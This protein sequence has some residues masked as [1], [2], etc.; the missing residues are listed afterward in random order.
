MSANQKSDVHNQADVRSQ[1]NIEAQNAK[2]NTP[3]VSQAPGNPSRPSSEPVIQSGGRG[4][5]GGKYGV[6]ITTGHENAYGESQGRS[7]VSE[8]FQQQT[9]GNSQDYNAMASE[10]A[11]SLVVNR[12]LAPNSAEFNTAFQNYLQANRLEQTKPE[13]A[14]SRQESAKPL[15]YDENY[16]YSGSTK[17][18]PIIANNFVKNPLE[19]NFDLSKDKLAAQYRRQSRDSFNLTPIIATPQSEGKFFGYAWAS[20]QRDI[21]RA[22]IFTG[23]TQFSRG[24]TTE[25]TAKNAAIA[26]ASKVYPTFA[27]GNPLRDTTVGGPIKSSGG[28]N[29]QIL[30]TENLGIGENISGGQQPK[31]QKG[32][33]VSEQVFNDYLSNIGSKGG[34]ID[35]FA[36]SGAK[37]GTV[38]PDEFG[39][40]VINDIITSNPGSYVKESFTSNYDSGLARSFADYVSKYGSEGATIGLF[41]GKTKVAEVSG[42]NAYRETIPLL[43]KY[44]NLSAQV[45]FST[46]RE[47]KELS[48][49]LINKARTVGS[50]TIDIF[51]TPQVGPPSKI[52]TIPT[53]KAQTLLP[54]ILDKYA[55]QN[56]SFSFNPK[57][58]TNPKDT[59]L[60]PASVLPLELNYQSSKAFTGQYFNLEQ[61]IGG[62]V[63]GQKAS[64]QL[65]L[66]SSEYKSSSLFGITVPNF[67]GTIS[68]F[69]SN[70]GAYLKEGIKSAP[71]FVAGIGQEYYNLI[72]TGKSGG[73]EV[74]PA[75]L[76]AYISIPLQK[77]F[78]PKDIMA[79]N[80][81]QRMSNVQSY[82]HTTFG[83]PIRQSG[84]PI[85]QSVQNPKTVGAFLGTAAGIGYSFGS[86]LPFGKLISREPIILEGKVMAKMPS[87]EGFVEVPGTIKIS[88]AT[89]F[90]TSKYAIGLGM[91]S[92]EGTKIPLI[93]TLR[94]QTPYMREILGKVEA[95][96]ERGAEAG[97]V[98]N[99]T[100][101][102]LYTSKG[103]EVMSEVGVVPENQQQLVNLGQLISKKGDITK[104]PNVKIPKSDV[105]KYVGQMILTGNPEVNLSTTETLGQGQV[106]GIVPT[107]KG[108]FGNVLP[109]N[110]FNKELSLESAKQ[111]ST[112]FTSSSKTFPINFPKSETPIPVRDITTIHDL[113]AD[114]KRLEKQQNL[115]A[116]KGESIYKNTEEFG[117][118]LKQDVEQ[119]NKILD[120]LQANVKV[121]KGFGFAK[122]GKTNIAYGKISSL[123]KQG[124]PQNVEGET[125]INLLGIRDEINTE[126]AAGKS[127]K[128]TLGRSFNVE[129]PKGEVNYGGLKVKTISFQTWAKL[130]SVLSYQSK[131][132]Y[133]KYQNAEPDIYKT[134]LTT[135]AGK[136]NIVSPPL[137]RVKDV[138]DLYSISRY[139]ERTTK[140]G[141]SKRFGQLAN[142]LQEQYP[143]LDWQKIGLESKNTV[144]QISPQLKQ[145]A[146]NNIPST[147]ISPTSVFP[148][149]ISSQSQQSKKLVSSTKSSF[150][151]ISRISGSSYKIS[152]T[153]KSSPTS[154][155]SS[156]SALSPT[157]PQFSP[158]SKASPISSISKSAKSFL[159]PFI[160]PRSF[161]SPSVS[162]P[163]SPR[164]SYS[165]ST[166]SSTSPS[167]RP[168]PSSPSGRTSPNS[169]FSPISPTSP[170]SRANQFKS[171]NF[172]FPP[173]SRN[174]PIPR[175]GSFPKRPRYRPKEGPTRT[176]LYNVNNVFASSLSLKAG[177]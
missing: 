146:K 36:P 23:Q 138:P 144:Y 173:P 15:S 109:I 134:G 49:N 25:E 165:P 20:G 176:Y 143:Y 57:S 150:S 120:L 59:T 128:Y 130:K 174:I 71:P 2:A 66:T 21:I 102:K 83:N 60:I 136:R 44:Q 145:S 58:Q 108:S 160:S 16:G 65:P 4:I 43:S 19:T 34:T 68:E 74:K 135:F 131:E 101:N 37:I 53:E 147:N 140:G 33:V 56:I 76:Q 35:V 148:T 55:T 27:K 81:A 112:Y 107:F 139:A 159:S 75:N 157:S 117:K 6:Q 97:A 105:K 39:K 156:V 30:L 95:T 7:N 153:S 88:G 79:E 132:T 133:G 69:G 8:K 162:S 48:S 171:P 72:T 113:D 31:S 115:Q 67:K 106:S 63:G 161:T 85:P 22:K 3:Q 87:G 121:P 167:G 70:L 18:A 127:S 124:K 92:S 5:V 111:Y 82:I 123:N 126:G 1:A 45:V 93:S 170:S 51:E 119:S 154:P 46:T 80:S 163:T 94:P 122:S 61:A 141:T 155:R 175:L 10:Y 177:K 38:K 54:G 24:S 118:V 40:S 110:Y 91:K 103:A 11:K 151:N 86:G 125:V 172:N 164:S 149:S 13:S 169:I 17:V 90:G 104:I 9:G 64:A 116:K 114:L 99:L 100:A 168:S 77:L 89:L 42:P 29:N 96:S 12:G 28:K 158:I 50:P 78:Y 52:A 73:P 137:I 84:I 14:A 152:G 41:Q 166:R 32:N 47:G 142:M 62:F 26:K 129:P 98:T